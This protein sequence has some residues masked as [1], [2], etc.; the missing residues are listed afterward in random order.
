MP[1][2]NIKDKNPARYERVKNEQ[3]RLAQIYGDTSTVARVCPFCGLK[4]SLLSD[5]QHD[6]EQRKCP[7]CGE[8]LNLPPVRIG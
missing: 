3:E 7:D 5:G 8:Q 4:L 2:V 1:K 6:A